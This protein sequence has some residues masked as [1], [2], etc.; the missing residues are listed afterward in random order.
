[1]SKKDSWIT[2]ESLKAA[3]EVV[4]ERFSND[5][6]PD[7]EWIPIGNQH[8]L[9]LWEDVGTKIANLYPVI[10]G[11]PDTSRFIRI[12]TYNRRWNEL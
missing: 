3:M 2:K 10:N 11:R 12:F 4:A 1:M 6:W 7:D 9:N 8:D 5:E